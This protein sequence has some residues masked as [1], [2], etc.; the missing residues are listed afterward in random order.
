[1]SAKIDLHIKLINQYIDRMHN[2]MILARELASKFQDTIEGMTQKQNT[3][4]LG[5][6]ER[7]IIDD[8]VL[9]L[10]GTKK[11]LTDWI[12]EFEVELNR[13][14]QAKNSLQSD[15]I[16]TVKYGFAEFVLTDT[17]FSVKNTAMMFYDLN[18]FLTSYQLFLTP[19][20]W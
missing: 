16:K 7:F 17:A 2:D 15:D 11:T 4:S 6:E 19:E 9:H 5:T 10:K 1:M 13:V 14:N 12:D 8:V 3:L 18:E 20:N